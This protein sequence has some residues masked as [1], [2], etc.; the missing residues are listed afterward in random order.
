MIH[1]GYLLKLSIVLIASIVNFSISCSSSGFPLSCLDL[2]FAEMSHLPDQ[3][4]L[5][6]T[7]SGTQKRVFAEEQEGWKQMDEFCQPSQSPTT[8]AQTFQAFNL[9]KSFNRITFY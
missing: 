8:L 3:I 2:P 4:P 7:G 1:V 5:I 6:H 9:H